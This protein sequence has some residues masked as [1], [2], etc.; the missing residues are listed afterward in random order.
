M[1]MVET[2]NGLKLK[3]PKIKWTEKRGHKGSVD[4]HSHSQKGSTD[5]FFCPSISYG[6]INRAETILFDLYSDNYAFSAH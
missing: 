5:P 4:I 2:K 6:K 1:K 3:T